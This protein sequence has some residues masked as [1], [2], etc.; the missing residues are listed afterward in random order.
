MG[1]PQPPCLPTI[2]GLSLL[3]AGCSSSATAPCDAPVNSQRCHVE[4]LLYRNDMLQAKMLI[5][6]GDLGNYELAAALLDRARANDVRGEA[7]FYRALLKIKE[8]PQVDE[9]LPLLE[10][11][12]GAGQPYAVALLYKI[13]SEPYL[14]DN[15]DPNKARRYQHAYASLDVARSGYPSFEQALTLVDG[16]LAAPSAVASRQ[17]QP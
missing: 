3:L 10:Q 13:W 7:S 5:A 15:A 8:G 4:R 16:L 2:L 14:V 11:A 6:S 17:A 1:Q 9:V 12:A